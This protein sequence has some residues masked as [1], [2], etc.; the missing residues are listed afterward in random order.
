[1]IV[2]DNGGRHPWG[3]QQ[4][5]DGQGI[6]VLQETPLSAGADVPADVREECDGLGDELPR[7]IMRANARVE[8][9][10]QGRRS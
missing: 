1:M 4:A 5:A 6:Q 10:Q 9:G 3:G 7:A 2:G 8:D